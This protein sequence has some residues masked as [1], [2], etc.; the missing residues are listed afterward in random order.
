MRRQIQQLLRENDALRDL[1]DQLQWQL[2]Q[3]EPRN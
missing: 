1:N 2:E 3:Y